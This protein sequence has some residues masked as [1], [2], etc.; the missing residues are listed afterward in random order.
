MIMRD[1]LDALDLPYSTKIDRRIPKKML[2]EHGIVTLADKRLIY[3]SIDDLSW[4]AALKP[5]TVGI[6]SYHDDIREVQE[7]AVL[8]LTLR[9]AS[10]SQ[11][12]IE[13][14]HRSIPYHLVL[15]IQQSSCI[16]ISLAQKRWSHN[17]PKTVVLD[18]DTMS[19]KLE[20]HHESLHNDFLS[21]LALARQPRQ[22]LM[23]VY[24]GWINAVFALNAAYI[25]GMFHL[26]LSHDAILRQQEALMTCIQ[27][28]TRI[29]H[30]H[31]LAKREKQMVR[32][33]DLNHE[34]KSLEQAYIA[35][36]EQ[37]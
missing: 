6:S 27:L 11:R 30:I 8:A 35:A 12:L 31:A 3:D 37:L 20:A 18:G 21:A 36:R 22:N 34:L 4:V 33:V 24:Q 13:L 26:P 14:V 19:A 5:T 2:V 17:S 7:I 1:V 32:L 15:V 16:T 10:K 29:A 28:S 9:G 23:T 25:T